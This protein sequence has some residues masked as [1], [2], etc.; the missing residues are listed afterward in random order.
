MAEH[1]GKAV[2]GEAVELSEGGKE[3]GEFAEVHRVK[4]AYKII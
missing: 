1:L 4:K 3:L 2:E